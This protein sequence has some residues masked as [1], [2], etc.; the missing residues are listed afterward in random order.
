MNI[1]IIKTKRK[2]TKGEELIINSL[3]DSLDSVTA[4]SVNIESLLNFNILHN[5]DLIMVI[6]HDFEISLIKHY[7]MLGLNTIRGKLTILEPR[8][9][10]EENIFKFNVSDINGNKIDLNKKY[11]ILLDRNMVW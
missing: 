10:V 11:G 8:F 2:C 9:S 4:D 5:Y 1:L 3:H 7:K 6:K